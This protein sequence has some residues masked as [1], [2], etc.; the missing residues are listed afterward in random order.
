MSKPVN[1]VCL[2]PQARQVHLEGEFNSW[3][4]TA[5]PMARQPD[6][7]WC[8]QVALH[9]GHHQYR[10]NVDGRRVLDPKASGVARN[11]EGEKVS[12]LAVS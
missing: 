8:V 6:G 12:L 1:F 2:A 4:P 11:Q 7:A 5:H 3:S 9:H 10:F